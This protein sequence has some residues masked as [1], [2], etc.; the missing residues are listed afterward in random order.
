MEISATTMRA[1]A[2]GAYGEP[3]RLINLPVPKP[4]PQDVLI[5]IHSAEVGHWDVRIRNGEWPMQRPFP[6]VLGLAGAGMVAAV[7]TEVTSFAVDDPVYAYSYPL[8]DN[9]AW[10]EYMLVPVS[11]VSRAPASLE[12]SRAGVV[13]I[14]GLTAHETVIDMLKVH[15]GDIVLITN[16]AGGVGHL[17]LQIAA[18]LGA[19]VVATA[20]PRNH[21]FVRALG[22][23]TVFDS[24]SMKVVKMIRAR[25]RQGVDKALNCVSSGSANP[26]VLALAEG[27]HMID[28]TGSV[29]VSRPGV[30]IDADYV[31]RGDGARLER[32]AQMIDAGR[33]GV[34]FQAVLPFERAPEA[35]ALVLDTHVRGKIGLRMA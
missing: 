4:G 28:L 30:R 24:L 31:A 14:V 21:E 29:S 18:G 10:A 22:A 12:L 13:P 6:L 26:M 7:G 23:V 25:Y 9:G 3:M 16:A 2:I 1:W 15:A 5:R 35:L 33:V 20:S 8:Y 27:G 11:Y 32:V 34:V 19:N 17:A